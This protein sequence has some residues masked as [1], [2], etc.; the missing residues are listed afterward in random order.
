MIDYTRLQWL[1][2]QSTSDGQY[3]KTQ[4]NKYYYKLSDY[5]YGSFTSHE[6]M[7]EVVASRVGSELGLPVLKY[8]GA[9]ASINLDGK[10]REAYIARSLNYCTEGK[11]S[12]PLNTYYFTNRHSNESPYQF[13]VRIGLK[14]YIENIIIFDYLIMGV[15]R[16][17]RNI[18]LLCSS[19]GV[20]PAPIFDN[21]RCLTYACGNRIENI[22]NY[23]YT[24]P[25]QGNNFIGGIDLERNLKLITHPHALKPLT[26]TSRSHI[27]YGLNKHYDSRHLNIIWTALCYRYKNL[28]DKGVIL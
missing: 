9:M 16:H 8:S 17:G 26:D 5:C 20:E 22:L 1:Y 14:E 23:D 24:V 10:I 12:M 13:C 2:G 28:K 18:E 19:K 3:L 27:F 4:D 6:S 15:D 11:S 25:G 21:G 7:L